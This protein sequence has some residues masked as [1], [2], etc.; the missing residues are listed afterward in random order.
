MSSESPSP[1][2][3]QRTE[4]APIT[5]SKMWIDDGNVV[6]VASQTQFRVHLSVLA[7]NSS[8]FRDMQGLPQPPDEPTIDGCPVVVLPDDPQD[9]EHLLN[10][11][12]T[13]TFLHREKLPFP[14]IGAL[15]RLGRKY[16][17]KD[18]FDAAVARLM[19]EFPTTLEAHDANLYYHGIDGF[20]HNNPGECE[21][22]HVRITLRVLLCS[23]A[24]F[25]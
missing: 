21:Q 3:R 11:L 15:I 9:I 12:Y 4:S 20:R 23:I 10:V 22:H 16:N 17:F 18:L 8:A 14:V 19:A 7:R 6:L 1:T 25:Y 2:K 13:P 5:R 24:Q